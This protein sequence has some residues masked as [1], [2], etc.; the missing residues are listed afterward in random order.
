MS[1][2]RRLVPPNNVNRIADL[3]PDFAT[4]RIL[5]G[6]VWTLELKNSQPAQM[7]Q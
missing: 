4:L 1:A 6:V 5:F 2:P 7:P 3:S